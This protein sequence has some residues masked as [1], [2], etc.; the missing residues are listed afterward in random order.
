MK[1][2]VKSN[3]ELIR[4]KKK[5]NNVGKVYRANTKYIDLD[6]KPTRNFVVLK[7]NGSFVTVSKLKTI[8]QFDDNN[9]N[10]DRALVE[11]NHQRYG[12]PNRTGVDFQRFDTNRM[13]NK[14]LT[15]KDI[16]AFPSNQESFK[17][18]SHDLNRVLQ[19]T[20]TIPRKRKKR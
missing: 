12:L 16:K 10:A 14:K 7:D 18:G 4:Q 9:K 15:L 2:N 19:H 3:V 17:L 1:K 20:N 13:T 5:S 6:T 11:I 8:K